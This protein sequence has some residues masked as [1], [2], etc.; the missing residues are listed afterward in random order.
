[1]AHTQLVQVHGNE[2]HALTARLVG[3]QA[4]REAA[5]GALEVGD[6]PLAG[7]RRGR[8]GGV[9]KEEKWKYVCVREIIEWFSCFL[10]STDWRLPRTQYP[11]ASASPTV[12]VAVHL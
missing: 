11:S 9:R 8:K 12:V 1:V 4:S 6:A 2:E 10:T 5:K 7:R 3:E